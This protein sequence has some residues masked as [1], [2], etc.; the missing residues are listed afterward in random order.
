MLDAILAKIFGNHNERE[1]KRIQ[2]QIEQ[3]NS[4]EAVIEALSDGELKSKTGEFKA[5]L[6]KGE[7]LKEIALIYQIF[8]IFEKHSEKVDFEL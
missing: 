3:I 1:L 4:L 6:D 5:R 8:I 7:Q 2:P